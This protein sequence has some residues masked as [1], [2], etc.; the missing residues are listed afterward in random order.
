MHERQKTNVRI[1]SIDV[2]LIVLESDTKGIIE[3]CH[4]GFISDAYLVAKVKVDQRALN[5]CLKFLT[6]TRSCR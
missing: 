1:I 5:W 6:R 4:V 3:H 2:V